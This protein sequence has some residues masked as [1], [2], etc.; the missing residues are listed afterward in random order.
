MK[1][2]LLALMFLPSVALGDREGV[3]GIEP[4]LFYSEAGTFDSKVT[5]VYGA[6]HNFTTEAADRQTLAGLRL[7]VPLSR[8]AE[9]RP[10]FSYA[11]TRQST[12]W[13]EDL[14]R[15]TEVTQNAWSLGVSFRLWVGEKKKDE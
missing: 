15:K 9:L 11:W 14:I 4:F 13:N 1:R 5:T 7:I 8:Q 12:T 3:I 2:L 10:Q 6:T